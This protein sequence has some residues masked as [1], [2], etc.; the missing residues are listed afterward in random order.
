MAKVVDIKKARLLLILADGQQAGSKTQPMKGKA[1]ER[2]FR[3][4]HKRAKDK[5]LK[6]ERQEANAVSARLA[7]AQS[8]QFGS[9]A[10][11]SLLYTKQGEYHQMSYP[12]RKLSE[13][14][15][16]IEEWEDTWISQAS[17]RRG[18]RRLVNFKAVSL[19][20]LDLDTYKHE[21]LKHL[22]PLEQVTHL[23]CFCETERLALPS[24][25]VFSGRGLQA[26]WLLEQEVEGYQLLRWRACQLA[27]ATK[28]KGM[29]ADFGALDPSRVLRLVGTKHSKSGETVR[30]L[31]GDPSAPVRYDFG[32][33]SEQLLS[34]SVIE[35]FEQCEEAPKRPAKARRRSTKDKE[36][37]PRTER[38]SKVSTELSDGLPHHE[39]TRETL[40]A[41]ARF[42]D[43]RKLIELRSP[44]EE[45]QRMFF[46]FWTL[47][48]FCFIRIVTEPEDLMAEARELVEVIDPTW[49]FGE[50]HL[51]TLLDKSRDHCS[52]KTILFQNKY[53]SPL[54]TPTNDYL[55]DLFCI[56]EA[57]QRQLT[58]IR[59]TEVAHQLRLA[60][61]EKI[62]RK[63]G[64]APRQDYLASVANEELRTKVL[65][66]R[67]EGVSKKAIGKQLSVSSKHVRRI[68]GE[69]IF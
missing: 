22:S 47:N 16:S 35:G 44:I 24:T 64:K 63:R 18:S 65:A 5:A 59:S 9:K 25:V 48:F 49:D 60:S 39:Y 27:L 23:L 62:N 36:T 8:Y 11:F 55:V 1:L 54:Y 67:S 69:D 29:K 42:W 57:E 33:L 3:L 50:Q 13:V 30:V 26:K 14:L 10:Y 41:N 45:G 17:F 15:I 52:G 58:S 37:K 6:D 4:A 31:Y 7:E 68:L 56:T 61:Y 20:F 2:A 40:I 19:F 28:L 43:L 51:S 38:L 32:E 46:L 21:Y 53:Y 12:V 66:M 34:R